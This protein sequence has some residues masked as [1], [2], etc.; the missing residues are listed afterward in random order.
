MT[1]KG[2]WPGTWAVNCDVCGFRFPSNKLQKRWD[3]AM[4]CQDDFEPR[5]PQTLIKVR[6]ETAVPSYTRKNPVE[7]VQFCD[8]FSRSAFADMGE[9]DCMQADRDN[10]SY[11]TLLDISTNGHNFP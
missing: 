7:Y 4:V 11:Q 2:R 3:G 6:G 5:H 1:W 9:A 10:P 8:I